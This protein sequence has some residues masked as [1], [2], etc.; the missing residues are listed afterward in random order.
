MA[1][2]DYPNGQ[3]PKSELVFVENM[4]MSPDMA[5]RIVTAFRAIRARGATITGTQGYRW[6][7]DSAD[8]AIGRNDPSGDEE[9]ANTTS[10][11]TG[12]QW[13]QLGRMDS[14]Y[15]PSAA[16][17]PGSS[18]H[19]FGLSV[20]TDCSDLDIRDEEFAKVGLRRDIP[21]ETWHAT[22]FRDPTITLDSLNVTAFEGFLMA[23]S[24]QKQE[25]MYNYLQQIAEALPQNVVA[26]ESHIEN[27]AQLLTNDIIAA[28]K[29]TKVYAVLDGPSKNAW[30]VLGPAIDYV[31]PAGKG[32]VWTARY[33]S[34]IPI[35]A[36]DLDELRSGFA[37]GK[38]TV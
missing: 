3:A 31:I 5:A 10:D 18:N 35:L 14:G 32:D 9:L 30:L 26:I 28:S 11:G 38:S 21:S 12:N 1:V 7:G 29:D 37:T 33:G 16:D 2:S 20:D 27:H 13:Y 15:T 19:G 23:L 8:R 6:L 36:A 25:E 24:D 22:I 17:P 4:W 34:I